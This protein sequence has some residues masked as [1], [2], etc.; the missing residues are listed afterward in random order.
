MYLTTF[1]TYFCQ[2]ASFSG[3]NMVGGKGGIE[4]CVLY[5]LYGYI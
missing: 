5:N 4:I 3:V 1:K 2:S